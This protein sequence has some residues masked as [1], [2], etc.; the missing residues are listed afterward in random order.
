MSRS[1]T[2]SALLAVSA[3]LFAGW[4][5][6]THWHFPGHSAGHSHAHPAQVAGDIHSEAGRPC[7][8]T[9]SDSPCDV[10]CQAGSE[11]TADF[12]AAAD[13]LLPSQGTLAPSHPA[14]AGD[15]CSIC[16]FLAG[17]VYGLVIV[18]EFA[19]M[20]AESQLIPELL[21]DAPTSQLR[22]ATCRGPPATAC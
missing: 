15:S 5:S 2:I 9:V 18:Y 22:L 16:D 7:C 13:S 17:H 19:G 10:A 20:V 3:L 8:A 21:F 6:V 14:H 11:A 4:T 12:E 1:R